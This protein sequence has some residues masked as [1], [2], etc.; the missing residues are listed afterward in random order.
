MSK[1]SGLHDFDFLYGSWAV[2][3]RRLKQWLAGCEEWTEFTAE[4]NTWP[5]LDGYANVDDYRTDYGLVGTAL[6][7]F[8]PKTGSWSIFWIAKSNPEM[9][10]HPVVGR[11]E[12]ATGI[13]EADDVFNDRAIRARF[14]WSRVDS[15]EP[16]WEQ[17][18][19]ADDGTTWETN[20]V[21]DYKR[22]AKLAKHA[23]RNV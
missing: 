10:R 11:F 3:A 14:T 1:D 6:R 12:G 23:R 17:A 8:N 4:L 2:R 16:H 13:F 5:L 20:W 21:M 22:V 7:L 15:A 19:S 9:D 18:F